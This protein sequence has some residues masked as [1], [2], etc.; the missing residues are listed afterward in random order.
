VNQPQEIVL[1]RSITRADGKPRP[2]DEMKVVA[3]WHR[4]PI[5]RLLYRLRHP[6]IG[7]A[8]PCA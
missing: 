3:Y 2:G 1:E 8:R 5:R 6:E 4:N 7:R